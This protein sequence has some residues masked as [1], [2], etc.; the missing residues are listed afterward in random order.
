MTNPETVQTVKNVAR[1]IVGVSTSFA[2]SN[3]LTNNTS[4]KNRLQKAE[5]YVA[6]AAV[7]G[8]AS[9]HTKTYTDKVVDEFFDFWHKIKTSTQN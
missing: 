8:V 4:P 9:E 1:L 5:V 3:A 2:V 6:S 7:G